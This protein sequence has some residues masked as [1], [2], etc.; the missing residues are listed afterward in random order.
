MGFAFEQGQVGGVVAVGGGAAGG[1]EGLGQ[2]AEGPVGAGLQKIQVAVLVVQL[3]RRGHVLQRGAGLAGGQAQAGAAGQQLGIVGLLPNGSVEG[4][5]L[6]P[7]PRLHGSQVH[8]RV[9][10]LLHG[11][12]GLAGGEHGEQQNQEPAGHEKE[13]DNDGLTAP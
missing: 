12:S 13:V 1:F 10:P 2:P 8:E 9:G 7:G 4:F 6:H 11:G 5:G 3:Q